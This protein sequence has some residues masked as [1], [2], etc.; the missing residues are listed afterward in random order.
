MAVTLI[1]LIGIGVG[2]IMLVVPMVAQEFAQMGRVLSGLASDPAFAD[3]VRAHLPNELWEWLRQYASSPDAKE[4]FSS[5]GATDLLQSVADTVLPGIKNV[6][7]GTAS[8]LTGLLGLGI[9]L[10]Y[11]IFL[12]ADFGSIERNWQDYLPAA[13]RES[14]PEFLS[15]FEITMSRYFRG[16]VTIALL[17]GV[18]L[19]IGFTIIKLPLAIVIGMFAGILNIAPYLGA[20]GLVPASLLAVIGAV[21]TGESPLVGVGL[22]L[23]VFAVVQIVQEAVLVPR[24]QGKGLGLSPWLILLALSIWGQL[25]GFL[26][27]LIALPMTCLCL[28]YYRRLLAKQE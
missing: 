20:I 1:G 3:K 23:L 9:I 4:L 27:L 7:R 21:E 2:L 5:Q 28:S 6:A 12:L 8:F 26:G 13:Y 19:S 11:V 15:E 10:L 17:V 22:V 18:L 25:L 14:V 24:I 16:Q